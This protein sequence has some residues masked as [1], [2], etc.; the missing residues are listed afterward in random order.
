MNGWAPP[1]VPIRFR[2]LAVYRSGVHRVSLFRG[3][4]AERMTEKVWALRADHRVARIVVDRGTVTRSYQRPEPH[5]P[6]PA[7]ERY[8]R[9]V[10]D[11]RLAELARSEE[12]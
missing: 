10:P 9:L 6:E 2:V 3:F 5:E 8:L 11:G 4:E 12:A 7:V 1:V